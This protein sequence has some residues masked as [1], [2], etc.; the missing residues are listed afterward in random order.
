[1]LDRVADTFI[2]GV[3]LLEAEGRAVRHNFT[4]LLTDAGVFLGSALLASIGLLAA[5]VGVTWLLA[6]STGWPAALVIIGGVT[7]A[8]FVALAFW[9][10]ARF[11]KADHT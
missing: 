11:N 7:A 8:T 6:R 9:A 3:E 2:A 10:H 1:M 5:L 4:R